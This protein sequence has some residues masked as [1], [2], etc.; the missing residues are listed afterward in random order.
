MPFGIVGMANVETGEYLAIDGI[1]RVRFELKVAHGRH[2]II[3][4]RSF[5]SQ[6]PLSRASQR[7]ASQR[8][9]RGAGVVSVADKGEV[10]ARLPS[11][12]VHYGHGQVQAFEHG[13][14]FDMELEI[15]GVFRGW[16]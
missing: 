10:E 4:A 2:A 1:A 3:H 11:D 5:D 12:R 15:G 16:F 7:V 8:H 14:L 6:D 13:P 9:R